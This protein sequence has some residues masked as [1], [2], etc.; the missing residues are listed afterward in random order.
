MAKKK[1]QSDVLKFTNKVKNRG[2]VRRH[3]EDWRKER[4]IPDR[5]DNPSCRFHTEPL[6][7][8][9]RELPLILDHINGVN[10]NDDPKNLR[11]LCP[12]CNQQLDTHGGGNKGRVEKNDSGYTIKEGDKLHTTA[13]V[14]G[15]EVRASAQP[16]SVVVSTAK[17]TEE[18]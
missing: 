15:V 2:L 3:Y 14:E 4:E 12:N 6:V 18:S 5:C 11:F 13:V 7:W 1:R 9:D 16:V 17:N 8:N 10:S